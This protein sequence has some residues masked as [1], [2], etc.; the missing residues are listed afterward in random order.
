MSNPNIRRLIL[1]VLKESR[2]AGENGLTTEEI[3]AR[4]KEKRRKATK[5]ELEL[6]AEEFSTIR[7]R[8]RP[9]GT[10]WT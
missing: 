4:V 5:R 7:N 2:A 10:R 3:T 8:V 1:I 9:T 6:M